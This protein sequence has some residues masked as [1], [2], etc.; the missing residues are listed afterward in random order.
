MLPI[1]SPRWGDLAQAFGSAEDV[2]RLL[3][4]LGEMDE[5]ARRELWLG[6]WA[7][8][9]RDGQVF[10]ASFAALPHLVTF[11][12]RVSAAERA[13]A[14]H[15]VGAIAVGRERP[16]APPMPPDLAAAYDEGIARIPALIAAAM[17]EPWDA[18]TTQVLAGVLAIAKGHRGFGNAVLA[19]EPLMTCPVCGELHTAPGW[20]R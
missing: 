14:L 11:A 17:G 4:A 16:D 20:G 12:G 2:P 15:L 8:L 18:D 5:P 3:S 6:L 13:R 7:T 10:S 1:E 19:L 9:W